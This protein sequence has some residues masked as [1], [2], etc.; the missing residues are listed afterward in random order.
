MEQIERLKEIEKIS[1]NLGEFEGFFSGGVSARWFSE[2]LNVPK[3]IKRC[4]EIQ[5]S[6]IFG[7]FRKSCRVLKIVESFENLGNLE[8]FEIFKRSFPKEIE[9]PHRN[10]NTSPQLL[11]NAIENRFSLFSDSNVPF[12]V[13]GCWL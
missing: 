10:S 3:E 13:L 5:R 9:N 1:I 4:E 11:T 6:K 7:E 12:A 8:S 2:K